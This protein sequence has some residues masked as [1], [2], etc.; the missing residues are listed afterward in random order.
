MI[1]KTDFM[2]L[3]RA[4]PLIFFLLYSNFS[5]SQINGLLTTVDV[6]NCQGKKFKFSSLFS[7]ENPNDN[8]IAWA[9][10]LDKNGKQLKT[11]QGK[12]TV[13]EIKTEWSEIEVEGKISKK[14]SDLTFGVLYVGKGEFHFDDFDLQVEGESVFIEN[15]NAKSTLPS[16]FFNSSK[17]INEKIQILSDLNNPKNNYVSI[18]RNSINNSNEKFLDINGIKLHFEEYGSGEPLILLHGA[19]QSIDAFDAMIPLLSKEYKVIAI[20]TRGHGK[21]TINDQ[22]LSYRLFSLDLEEFINKMNLNDVNIL[23]WS[24]GGNTG[25]IYSMNNPEKVKKLITIGA[26]LFNNDSSVNKEVNE[27]LNKKIN[28]CKLENIENE[29]DCRVYKMLKIHPNISPSELSKIQAKTLILS[30]ENDFV[31]K[32]HSKL[33]F[34]SINNSK[35]HFFNGLTHDAPIENPKLVSQYVL[36]FL[37][38]EP[39]N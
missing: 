39:S 18:T 35:I 21:S 9:A 2:Y 3:K 32:S 38:D 31:K 22:D 13:Q 7:L 27:V 17:S 12:P 33:I 30:G 14:T 28:H 15:F 6:T 34:E 36:D 1:L 5:N 23:G 29:I 8:T 25:L 37:N 10:L 4:L 24:D 26:V 11:F 20:D 19:L 16:N